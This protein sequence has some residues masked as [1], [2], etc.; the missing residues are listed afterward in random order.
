MDGWEGR[1]QCT[2]YLV[3]CMIV[4]IYIVMCYLSNVAFVRDMFGC[5]YVGS[6]P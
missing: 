2:T 5:V 6:G 4:Y 1:V 3:D